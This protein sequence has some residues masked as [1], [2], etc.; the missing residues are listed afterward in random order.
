MERAA[1]VDDGTLLHLAAL[2]GRSS[3]VEYFISKGRDANAKSTKCRS[4]MASAVGAGWKS[5]RPIESCLNI[6]NL[7]IAKGADLNPTGVSITPL[8]AAIIGEKDNKLVSILLAFG[9]DVNSVGEDEANI[10]RLRCTLQH[11]LSQAQF[12][13]DEREKLGLDLD[14]YPTWPREIQELRHTTANC[15]EYLSQLRC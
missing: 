15:R 4:V 3:F 1:D 2:M 7:L 11:C 12:S 13:E 14:S 9:A 10:V 8:Q 5:W 6:V